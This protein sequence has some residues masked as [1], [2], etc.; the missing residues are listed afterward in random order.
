MVI[1][2]MLYEIKMD[3]VSTVRYRFGTISD[4]VVYSILLLFFIYSGTGKSY[5]SVYGYDNYRELFL[6]GYIA[7]FFSVSAISSISQ[8]VTG[9]LRQGTFY[10]KLNSKCSLEFLLFGRFI[11]AL[12][13]EVVIAIVILL[14][15]IAFGQIRIGLHLEIILPIMV[16]TLGMYGIGLGIAG[17][18]LFYKRVG[19]IT[20]I[21]QLV[22]LFLTDTVS[23]SAC[24]NIFSKFIPLTLCNSLIRRQIVGGNITKDYIVLVFASLMWMLAGSCLFRFFIRK[25]KK[26]GNILFY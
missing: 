13:V 22:L 3:L 4:I 14:V 20:Y 23:T 15:G 17:V 25:A 6:A 11:A 19:A 24:V 7:W 9:E 12:V 16:C 1:R 18:A 5:S 21:V 10:R 2:S 8:I 26:E